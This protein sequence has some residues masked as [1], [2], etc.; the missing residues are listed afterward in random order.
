MRSGL[1][2]MTSVHVHEHTSL[3]KVGECVVDAS[4]V[5]RLRVRALLD[6]EVGDQVG[7]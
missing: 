4:E 1:T 6:T 5:S 2:S 3:G 7:E